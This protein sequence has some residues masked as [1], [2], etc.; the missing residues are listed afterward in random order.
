MRIYILILSFIVMG[1][2][3]NAKANEYTVENLTF[4][5]GENQLAGQLFLP[6]GI[7]KPPV[8]VVT[9]AWTTVKEQ[10]PTV[11]AKQLVDNGYAAF[12]FDF[13]GWGMSEGNHRF[14]EDPIAK[15]LDIEAAVEFVSTLENVDGQRI[16]GLGICAS[17][18]YMV[19]AFIEQPKLKTIALVA[20]WLHNPEIATQVYG[21]PEAVA[22]LVAASQSAQDN[23]D[24]TGQWTT[25]EAASAT[26]D[27]SLMYQA[28]YYTEKDRGLISAYDNQFNIASWQP[29]LTFD[30][31]SLAKKLPGKITFVHSEDAVIPH[32]VKQFAEL[33]GDKVH[34]VWLDNI[35][36]FEFYDQ[37]EPV[38]QATQ[39]VVAHYKAEL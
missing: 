34:G 18:G 29:W 17:S 2:T 10:M 3:M 25:I 14:V 30:A 9:G 31:I 35:T 37:K 24:K 33:G 13:T 39:V 5:S 1:M 16:G 27:K 11:Y 38:S 7:E 32:G 21:G 23:F 20:T 36:Q 4:N 28:P 22:S 19:K 26:N 15:T 6:T 12:I 8:V